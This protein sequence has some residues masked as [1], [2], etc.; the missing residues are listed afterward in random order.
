[1]RVLLIAP[2]YDKNVPGESWSTYK[3]I[4]G[5][6][7]FHETTVLTT[8]RESWRTEA[9]P[10]AAKQVVNWRDPNLPSFLELFN[11]G[12][13]PTYFLFYRRAR[14]WIAQALRNG[15]RFDVAHQINPL[16]LRY[17]SPLASFDIPYF[18]GPLAGSLPTPPALANRKTAEP[19]YRKLRAVDTLRLRYD[20]CLKKTYRKAACILGVAP[21]VKHLLASCSIRQIEY[22]SETG[23]ER[24][25]KQSKQF[26][27]SKEKLRLLFVGRIIA[28]KGILDAIEAVGR[29]KDRKAIEFN[30][31]GDGELLQTCKARAAELRLESIVHFH[32]RV[33]R[34]EVDWWYQQ[35]HV[36]LFP[37]YREPSGNVVLESLGSGLPVITT[38]EG[39][40][41]YVVDESCGLRVEPAEP[42]AFAQNLAES[43]ERFLYFPHQVQALSQGALERAD[44]L[45]LWERKIDRL[46][47]LY[48]DLTS[49]QSIKEYSC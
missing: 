10:T 12:A 33:P 41:G 36:F 45:G 7:Q 40:P 25:A 30:V 31:F 23:V 16:A 14:A 43:I 5:I 42:G 37:S 39:G 9:S 44:A 18:M 28:T 21:Y 22:M 19:F 46:M 6:S 1:M 48:A 11:R 49:A 29:V 34:K 24:V 38:T 8:H 15:E 32:G 27:P 47:S 13:K 26:D 35:S 20:P 2:Y 17:P 4:E 3:W